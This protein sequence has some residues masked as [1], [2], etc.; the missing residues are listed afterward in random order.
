MISVAMA[1]YNGQDYIVKQLDSI[2]CQTKPVDQCIIVDECSTDETVT[3][4][5]NYQKE[6]PDLPICLYR[7]EQNLGYRRNFKKAVSLTNGDYIF[8]C[9]SR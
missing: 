8:L 3:I 4:I 2:R 9:D 7:N 6:H 5:E 1:S